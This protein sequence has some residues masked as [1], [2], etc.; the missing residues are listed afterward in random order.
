[1]PSPKSHAYVRGS[2]SGS[3]EPV[4]L[5]FT[6]M[7]TVPLYGPSALATGGRF[8]GAVTVMLKDFSLNSPPVSVTRT[9]AEAVPASDVAGARCALPVAVPVPG[10]VVV[11][12]RYNGPLV[13]E[14]VRGLPS[15][16]VAFS[17]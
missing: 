8:C 5:K 4:P 7:P 14:N 9:V 11:T 17:V 16:S 13:F 6:G 15:G 3:D 2:P 1:M 10:D 12:V